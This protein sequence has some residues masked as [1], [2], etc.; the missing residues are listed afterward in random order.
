MLTKVAKKSVK[1]GKRVNTKHVDS[2]IKNYKRERWAQNSKNLG[3]EDSLSVWYSLEELQAF[4]Q[5]AKESGSDGVRLYFGVYDKDTAEN[6]DFE[7]RQTIVFVA[8][9]AKEMESGTAN[10][11]VF[12]QT[13]DGT[14]I[15]A[16]NLGKICPPSCGSIGDDD[17]GGFGYI[18][19]DKGD[20]GLCVV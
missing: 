9:K 2:L 4:L 8:T 11:E 17:G 18:L 1:A 7:G 13:E 20:E 14:S 3:K 6:P 5:T 16:Y 19:I 10:K 15:L 12:V